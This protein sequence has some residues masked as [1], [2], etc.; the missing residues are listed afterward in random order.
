MG[1][2]VPIFLALL[3][4]ACV[5]RYEIAT[6]YHK[7]AASKRESSTGRTVIFFLVDGMGLPVFKKELDR[8]RLPQMRNYFVSEKNHYFVARTSFPSL[9]YPGISSLL[10]EE[11]IERNGIFGNHVLIEN[12]AIDFESRFEVKTLN[13]MIQHHDVFSRVESK[14]FKTV[15]IG[16]AFYGNAYVHTQMKDLEAGV[17]VLERDYLYLDAKSIDA[18]KLLLKENLPSKWPDFIFVHLVGLDFTSHDHGPLSKEAF[19]YLEYLDAKLG[20]VFRILE[21]TETSGKHQVTSL[22]SADHGFDKRVTNILKIEDFIEHVDR[23]IKILNESRYA[24]LYF[25]RDWNAEKRWSFLN[26]IG[27][28]KEIELV[29]QRTDHDVTIQSH[30]LNVSFRYVVSDGCPQTAFKIN[31]ADPNSV[32]SRAAFHPPLCPERL[33]SAANSLFFPY[34]IPD[35][36]H[37]FWT[38]NHPDALIIPKA[39]IAFKPKDRGQHG[40]PTPQEIFVPLLLHKASLSDV[41]HIPKLSELLN[42][43]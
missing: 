22:L 31:I 20:E 24:A 27:R 35:L 37:Y 5:S 16:Y 11:A 32:V 21:V 7:L 19:E 1:T 15:S 14:G 39:G 10:T 6:D 17:S 33:D 8:G 2:K 9:T 41:N 3:V 13:K 38:P 42:F 43:M 34:F 29:A 30:D 26:E 40:G 18:L 28:R 23:H 25:P 12:K 4:S 36:S